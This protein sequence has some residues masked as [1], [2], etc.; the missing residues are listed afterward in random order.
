MA[1]SMYGD[2]ELC[3]ELCMLAKEHQSEDFRINVT[4]R[5]S[6]DA[7]EKYCQ[8]LCLI[9]CPNINA[10]S[11]DEYDRDW[12]NYEIVLDSGYWSPETRWRRVPKRGREDN[13]KEDRHGRRSSA[14]RRRP[15]RDCPEPQPKRVSFAGR[16]FVNYM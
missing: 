9:L 5:L 10:K 6:W 11:E 3:V 1:R 2:H 4:S 16:T 7:K 14:G 8:G 12:F 15:T 13:N